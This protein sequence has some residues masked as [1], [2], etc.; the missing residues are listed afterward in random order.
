MFQHPEP[1]STTQN[2]CSAQKVH[3]A[4]FTSFSFLGLGIIFVI[5]TFLIILSLIL[6]YFVSIATQPRFHLYGYD[7]WLQ[8]DPL[9]LR[10]RAFEESGLGTWEGRDTDVPV[11]AP[12]Q[13]MR[14]LCYKSPQPTFGSS[15]ART[16]HQLQAEMDPEESDEA[17]LLR[18]I[19]SG[20]NY[21]SK[22]VGR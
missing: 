10:Q 22:D 2:F 20:G 1:G 17:V 19:P 21:S 7:P 11:T 18:P 6:P 4:D 3:T 14:P 8:D 5:G 12:G 13:K 15:L 16:T 9:H